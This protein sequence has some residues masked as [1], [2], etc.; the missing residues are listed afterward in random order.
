VPGQSGKEEKVIALS[1]AESFRLFHE[2]GI[3][4]LFLKRPGFSMPVKPAILLPFP[5]LY[6]I[7]RLFLHLTWSDTELYN[8]GL[9]DVSFTSLQ[10]PALQ[11]SEY[12]GRG[13]HE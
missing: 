12:P 10:A 6:T 3:D 11:V 13:Y 9:P 7:T 4:T 1:G 8:P 5:G 2:K